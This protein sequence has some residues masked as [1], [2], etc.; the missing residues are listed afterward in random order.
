MTEI[1][2]RLT[3]VQLSRLRQELDYRLRFYHSEE[4]RRGRSCG[5]AIAVID[6]L[7]TTIDAQTGRGAAYAAAK[8]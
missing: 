7:L 6:D 3:A 1:T 4:R 5:L 2:I 8:T